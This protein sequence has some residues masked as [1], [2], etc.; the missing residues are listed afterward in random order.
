MGWKLNPLFELNS[1]LFHLQ[2]P[3]EAQ[4]LPALEEMKA[5]LTTNDAKE[6]NNFFVNVSKSG[7][8]VRVGTV[9][10]GME[11]GACMIENLATAVCGDIEE[12]KDVKTKHVFAVDIREQARCVESSVAPPGP[13]WS[14]N[15]RNRSNI[16]YGKRGHQVV[17]LGICGTGR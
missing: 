2:K 13:A 9:G 11:L 3:L 10:A 4:L 5:N 7:S 15:D 6:L 17:H 8:Q 1:F 12:F 16:S 14:H